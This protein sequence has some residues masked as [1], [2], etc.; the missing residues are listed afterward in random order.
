MK[1]TSDKGNLVVVASDV[2]HLEQGPIARA[3]VL[4]SIWSGP[5]TLVLT[6]RPPTSI[7]SDV[8]P[9]PISMVQPDEQLE[10]QLARSSDRELQRAAVRSLLDTAAD[11]VPIERAYVMADEELLALLPAIADESPNVAIDVELL[12]GAGLPDTAALWPYA[13]TLLAGDPQIAYSLATS[14]PAM[15]VRA[16]PVEN[17]SALASVL[18]GCP[19][20]GSGSARLSVVMPARAGRLHVLRAI[21]AV[22]ERTPGLLEVIV[23][24]D[25]SP[26]DTLEAIGERAHDEPRLRVL[27]HDRRH[28]FAATCNRGLI[29]ARGDLITF[30]GADTVVS[31]GWSTHFLAALESYPKAG[32]VGPLLNVAP[33]LQQLAPVPY[34]LET[35]AGF[36]RFSRRFARGNAGQ[37]TPMISLT[38]TCLAVPRRALRVVGGFDPIYYPAGFE[39]ED[40]C[41]RLRA[42]GWQAYRADDVFV[43]HEGG[44][45]QAFE[46]QR[47]E[48]IREHTWGLFKDKWGLPIDRELREGFSIRE[49]PAERF[50]RGLHYI[51]PWKATEPVTG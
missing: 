11:P 47:A 10:Q 33:A 1:A 49:L 38:G 2:G 48:E 29:A 21:E 32:A 42:A 18:S 16:L 22:L 17:P 37:V 24:D 35:L 30:L 26:D 39:D 7:G 14:Q 44:A 25:A 40:W 51:A 13:D 31:H 12:R 28:G 23:I 41:I 3:K 15:P 34:D 45:S 46:E 9:D 6:R 27:H 50:E 20:I 36:D 43:H 4:A 5:V 8:L 19:G